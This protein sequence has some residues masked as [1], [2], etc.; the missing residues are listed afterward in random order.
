MQSFHS[1]TW[2]LNEMHSSQ[3]TCWWL[4]STEHFALRPLGY[5]P[6]L[7]EFLAV[8]YKVEVLP[9]CRCGAALAWAPSC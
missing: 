3:P 2:K 1:L 8:M 6:F 9:W 4:F 7:R 5:L